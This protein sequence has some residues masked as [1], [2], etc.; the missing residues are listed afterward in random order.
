MGDKLT[1]L[2]SNLG[3]SR[4]N[5]E[6][7]WDLRKRVF[8]ELFESNRRLAFQ[9][10]FGTHTDPENFTGADQMMFLCLFPTLTSHWEKVSRKKLQKYVDG[11]NIDPFK[12][13][14]GKMEKWTEYPGDDPLTLLKTKQALPEQGIIFALDP[15]SQEY[16]EAI[17][18]VLFYEKWELWDIMEE[19]V[20]GHITISAPGKELSLAIQNLENPDSD[21][22]PCDRID[23]GYLPMRFKSFDIMMMENNYRT[24][25]EKKASF[26][27]CNYSLANWAGSF[28][29]VFKKDG[30]EEL[31]FTIINVLI[32][33]MAISKQD[34][35]A[36]AK[37][38]IN[39][40]V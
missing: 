9:I 16:K 26:P 28:C 31:R 25:I 11:F 1:E 5:G 15:Y 40:F 27:P 6:S 4:T 32:E 10:L 37:N 19:G 23:G 39:K 38:I 18:Q 20:G 36:I 17:L 21:R 35:E 7:D 12:K 24:L 13:R 34:A 2:C 29:R 33:K 30:I 8:V 3:Y 22:E 14:N